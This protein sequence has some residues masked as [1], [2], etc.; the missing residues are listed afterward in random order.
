MAGS[1]DDVDFV[2][3]PGNSRVFGQNRHA[4]FPL[5]LIGIHDRV[6]AH[7]RL[8]G[9]KGVRL[10]QQMIHERGF[11]VIDVGNNGDIS[12]FILIH[13]GFYPKRVLYA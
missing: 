4:P 7:F 10:L 3:L 8:V 6:L 12:D 5:Q 2:A 9:G 1:V 11:A 13:R